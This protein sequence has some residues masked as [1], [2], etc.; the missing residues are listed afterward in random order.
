MPH[1]RGKV[2]VSSQGEK[3]QSAGVSDSGI[4]KLSKGIGQTNNRLSTLVIM[5]VGLFGEH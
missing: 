3:S 4:P 2:S 5:T 1:G